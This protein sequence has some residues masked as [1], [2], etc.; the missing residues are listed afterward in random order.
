[1]VIRFSLFTGVFKN[2]A[3]ASFLKTPVNKLNLITIHL[4]NGASI[5]AIKKG[6]CV[7]TT[8]GMTPLEGLVMGTRPGDLDPG[9][10]TLLAREGW[11]QEAS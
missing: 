6:I 7:D 2:E 3:A 8:M 11:N 9:I 4:G 1:M 5:S 10:L